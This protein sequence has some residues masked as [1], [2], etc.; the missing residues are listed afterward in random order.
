MADYNGW[1]NWAT[2]NVALWLDNEYPWYRAKLAFIKAA[3]RD[4]DDVEDFVMGLLPNGTPDFKSEGGVKC[5]KDVN[6]DE[7]ATAFKE[8]ADG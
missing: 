5:Y 8:D 2:W 3:P 6:W 7:L 4:A 1:T